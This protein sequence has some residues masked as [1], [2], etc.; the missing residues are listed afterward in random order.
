MKLTT[1]TTDE[2][3]SVVDIMQDQAIYIDSVAYWPALL[4]IKPLTE[5]LLIPNMNIQ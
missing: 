5:M 1:K 4:L 3:L 2:Y